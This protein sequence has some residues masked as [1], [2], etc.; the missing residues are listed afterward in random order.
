MIKFDSLPKENPGGGVP[1]PGLY[2]AKVTKAEMKKPKEA[3]KKPYL[4]L[5][6]KLTTPEGK[7]AGTM[8]DMLME[9]DNVTIMYKLGRFIRACGIPLV[10]EMELSDLAK[11]VVNKT[12]GVDVKEDEYNGKKR[13][14][15]NLFDR[16]AYYTPEE[17][18]DVVKAEQSGDAANESFVSEQNAIPANADTTVPFDDSCD[19]APSDNYEPATTSADSAGEY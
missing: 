16:E 12:I 13:A 7:Q 8:F 19:P 3:D 11:L 1:K 9:S 18:P 10:G 17:F 15:I 6:Y 4:S 2:L 5:T 14:A